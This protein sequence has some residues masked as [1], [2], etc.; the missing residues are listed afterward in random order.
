MSFMR[1][2]GGLMLTYFL[3]SIALACSM[4]LAFADGLQDCKQEQDQDIAISGCDEIIRADPKADW[5][6]DRR[7]LAYLLKG[8][9]SGAVSDFTKAIEIDPNRMTSYAGRGNAYIMQG[10]YDHAIADY[11]K[12]IQ[13]NPKAVNLYISRG[14]SYYN[15]GDFDRAIA[16]YTKSIENAPNNIWGYYVRAG[17][18][19]RTAKY[20]RAIADY[21]RVM[22]INP[23]DFRAYKS[24]GDD[25]DKI[26]DKAKAASDYEVVAKL[27]SNL[28]DAFGCRT[29]AW[30]LLKLGR[31]AEALTSARSAIELTPNDSIALDIRGR[32]LEALGQRNEAIADFQRAL[33]INPRMKETEDTLKTLQS[34]PD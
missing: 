6:Y 24:R 9:S 13:F 18:Y 27:T 5:A 11:T 28:T 32:I 15:K 2:V 33:A 31:T 14:T 26:G 30:A 1:S 25:Y 3:A 19:E 20:E 16:D 21:S 4:S 10:D 22:V 29:R 8:N 7:A 23:D 34:R 12:V 17:A